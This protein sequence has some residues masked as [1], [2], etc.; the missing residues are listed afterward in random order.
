MGEGLIRRGIRIANIALGA[1][2][3]SSIQDAD[4]KAIAQRALANQFA[5]ARGTVMKV[6]QLLASADADN[7]FQQLVKGIDA[8]PLDI[9]APHIEASLGQP[10]DQV[11][12]SIDESIAAASLGQVHH[13][14]LLNGHEVAVKIQYPDIA[15]KVHSEIK[16]IGLMPGVGPVKKWG[17]DLE[18]YK[19]SFKANMDLELDYETEAQ[20]QLNYRNLIQVDGLIIPKVYSQFTR[21]NLLIQSWES[22]NYLDAINDW[23][24]ENRKK[25]AELILGTLFKSLF[26]VGIVHGDPH[27]GNSYF[28]LD[29]HQE[30]EMVLMDFGCTINISE[31]QRLSLLKLILS[32]VDQT[33]TS[34]LRY[35]TALGFDADKLSN[36]GDSLPMIS[37]LLFTPFIETGTFIINHW[38]LEKN[39]NEL[40]GDRRWWFRSAGPSQLFLIMRAFQGAMQQL[41][42]LK[43]NVSWSQLLYKHVSQETLDKARL[44][45]L[46]ELQQEK[47]LSANSIKALASSLKVNVKEN[48]LQKVNISLP[49]EMALQLESIMPEDVL[50]LLH[51][52]PEIDLNAIN[53]KIRLSGIA[54]QKIFDLKNGTKEYSVWLE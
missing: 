5:D 36:I 10:L 49:V 7:N 52:T 22:G 53:Q 11:F 54:P 4:Q 8:L 24:N 2:K 14:I 21:P 38:D 16:L 23:S 29:Q 45:N 12:E 30:P 51:K 50:A 15:D 37:K 19:K 18:S 9:I 40:L 32:T 13:A 26:E 34:P 35:F 41:S 25:C 44:L 31:K 20:T 27:I 43:T 6:G 39:F 48:G 46:P 42:I 28:R 3:L 1:K 47:K 33:D 17:F